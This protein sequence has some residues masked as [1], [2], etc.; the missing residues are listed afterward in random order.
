MNDADKIHQKSHPIILPRAE[1]NTILILKKH[2][3]KNNYVLSLNPRAQIER[4]CLSNF[5]D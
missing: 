4:G 2:Y 1:K 5:G 3:A